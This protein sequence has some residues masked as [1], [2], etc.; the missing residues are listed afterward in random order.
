MQVLALERKQTGSAELDTV[1]SSVGAGIN[2]LA[3]NGRHKGTDRLADTMLAY[4]EK[5]AS[6]IMH[7]GLRF[8]PQ[9]AS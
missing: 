1:G 3:C 9:D 4:A 2:P 6:I 8:M 7:D 5:G